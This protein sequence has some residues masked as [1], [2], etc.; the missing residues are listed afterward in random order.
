MA[1]VLDGT[2]GVNPSA[3]LAGTGSSSNE[4]NQFKLGQRVRMNDGQ[5]LMYVHASAAVVLYDAVG[6]DENFEAAP[7]TKAMADD[8]WVVGFSQ[9][10]VADNEFFWLHMEGS[11]ITARVATSCAA[12]V[13]LYTTSNAGIL[14]DT[15]ASQ[16][17]IQGVTAVA[18]ATSGTSPVE[19]IAR[20][21]HIELP[22]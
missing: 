6:V 20:A 14:D 16:T 13:A 7:L 18:A 1:Y 21:V 5:E 22:A 9:V 15:S 10:T 19:V 8:A 4:G 3:V 17:K 2:I 11:N 12:D